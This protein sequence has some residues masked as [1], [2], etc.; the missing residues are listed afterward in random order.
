VT[1]PHQPQR[2]HEPQDPHEPQPDPQPEPG[3]AARTD[4]AVDARTGAGVEARTGPAVDARTDAEFEAQ[5]DA[6]LDAEFGPREA[7]PHLP[8]P[9]A[10]IEQAFRRFWRGYA[11]FSG[12]ASRSEYWWATL[13]LTVV[14][15]VA[16]VLPGT[17]A[18][19]SENLTGSSSVPP[20]FV[21]AVVLSLAWLLGTIVPSFAVTAR[22]L[23]DGN[24][25]ALFL[26][27]LFV[28]FGS[29]VVFVLTLL[30]SRPEGARFDRAR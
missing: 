1:D 26:L 30:E 25:S 12:R 5:V 4:A 20:V 19:L 21:V 10:T 2:P 13:V 17:I 22:R 28:P 16:L 27:L 6:E 15:F 14:T 24:F 7:P 23:H 11:R 3:S 8:Q 29:I 18:I 9:G